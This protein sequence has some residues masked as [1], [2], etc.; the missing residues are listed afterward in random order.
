MITKAAKKQ[1]ANTSCPV[2]IIVQIL[3]DAKIQLN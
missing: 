3:M 2:E 1:I